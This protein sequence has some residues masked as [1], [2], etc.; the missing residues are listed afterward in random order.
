MPPCI[1]KITFSKWGFGGEN[2]LSF[3]NCIL[4]MILA[5]LLY[6]VLLVWEVGKGEIIDYSVCYIAG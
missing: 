3:L 6:V 5:L 2:T 1:M 4:K